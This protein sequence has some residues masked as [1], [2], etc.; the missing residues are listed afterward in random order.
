MKA[1]SKHP[2]IIVVFFAFLFAAGIPS[3]H[4]SWISSGIAVCTYDGAQD[5][6]RIISDGTGGAIITWRDIRGADSD[7]YA[8]RIDANGTALWTTDGEAVCTYIGIQENP[9]IISDGNGG[10]IITWRD[11][12]NGNNDLYAQRINADGNVQWKVDGEAI[13]KYRGGQ[14]YPRI[15]S[16][17]AGG[18]IITWRDSRYENY[19]ICMQRIEADGTIPWRMFGEFV[20]TAAGEQEHPRITSDGV[21]GVFIAWRDRRS[22]NY[23]IYVRRIDADGSNHTGWTSAG[24]AICTDLGEQHIPRIMADEAGGAIITWWDDRSGD[25]DI[26]AQRIDAT[27]GIQWTANGEAVCTHTGE[28]DNPR[29]ISDGAGGAVVTWID[30]RNGSSDIYTQRVDADG[31]I[32][33]G[34]TVD[35]EFIGGDGFDPRIASDGAGGAIITWRRSYGGR[36]EIYVQRID[37]D[38]AV[39][40][41]G[42]GKAVCTCAGDQYHPEIASDGVG[43]AVITWDEDRGSGTDI[44]ARRPTGPACD[45]Q[46]THIDFGVVDVWGLKDTTFTIKSTGDVPLVGSISETSEYFS[47]ISERSYDLAPGESL[48]VT[49]R[50]EPTVAG[51]LSCAIETGIS[52]LCSTVT[53]TGLSFSCT[54]DTVLYVD[55]KAAGAGDGCSWAQAYKELRDALVIASL[56]PSVAEIRVAEGTYTPTGAATRSAT[57][58]LQNNLALYGGFSGSETMLDERDVAVHVTILSGDVGTPGDVTDNSYHVVTGSGTDIT[59]VL[60]GFTVTGGNA[61]G[62]LENSKGAGMYNNGGSPTVAN[63]VITGNSANQ[64]GGGMHN[65][66]YGNVTIDNVVF[67][68]N[69]ASLT[70][71]GMFNRLAD[72]MLTNVVFCCNSSNIGIALHNSHASPVLVNV[73]FNG[74]T[75]SG[76]GA[77]IFN[78]DNSNPVLT[79]VIMWGDSVSTWGE[80]KSDASSLPA[81]SYSLIQ[82]CGSSGTGWDASL[83]SDGGSNIDSDPLFVDA[84]GGDLRLSIDSEANDAG[85]STV[86]GLPATDLSGNPR[87]MGET[88][89]MGAYEGEFRLFAYASIDSI[90]DV[91]NDQGGWV[92]IHFRRSH[93]DDVIE[94]AHQTERYD[95]HRRMDDPGPMTNFPVEG[96]PI[97]DKGIRAA[98]PGSWEL[99]GTVPAQWQDLYCYDVPAL[100]DSADTISW[101]V[102]YISAHPTAPAPSFDSPSDS[103]YSVDNLPPGLPTGFMVE[104]NTGNGNHLSWDPCTDDDFQFFK[105]YRDIEYDAI[106]EPGIEVHATADT[107]WTDPDYDGSIV[108]YKLTALDDACNESDFASPTIITGDEIPQVPMVF[109][110]YQNVPNPFN[111]TTMIRFDVPK[112]THVK[113]CIFNVEGRL[114]ATVVDRHMT[115]GRKE[116]TWSAKDRRGRTVASGIYFYRLAAG[117]FVQARK[118]V[119]LR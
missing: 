30:S 87:I 34:W 1:L 22:G 107:A 4:A 39:R 75:T 43:G 46:P 45:I 25:S 24:E 88:V 19:D 104:F 81:I 16:D 68:D 65:S 101:S 77:G 71:G 3:L 12:R 106:P 105:I 118:M 53:A 72:P 62:E 59:A 51:R 83:G 82:N 66:H 5:H 42:G 52:F 93:Y 111:P 73:T 94:S 74:N 96:K 89:D 112:P 61:D 13:C 91:P 99:V 60:D 63:A 33:A 90:V 20:C 97:A 92:S 18:A 11:H 108:N 36:E 110:L 17:G 115:G 86:A 103:G 70:G 85:D 38:G 9:R 48:T 116:V 23:D 41:E 78:D 54:P 55:E 27:G 117:D 28:Q 29:I 21:G 7:I 113:L 26:Y 109:A 64:L 79:N 58:Q 6:P 44:Y 98:P 102:Y 76:F 114:V 57:F 49:V 119:I 84:F 95:I 10:A 67:K 100:A 69:F 37:A 47:I 50:F 31:S 35:G 40:W 80:I 2:E 15:T 14:E 8:Q 56:C 32:H